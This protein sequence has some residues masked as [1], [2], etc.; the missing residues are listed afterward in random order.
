M[1][2]C[3]VALILLAGTVFASAQTAEQLRA[4]LDSNQD[5]ALRSAAKQ[6]RLPEFY[7]GMVEASENKLDPARRDL[8]RTIRSAPHSKDALDAREALANMALRNGL[9]REALDQIEAAHVEKPGSADVN[10]ML[11]LFRALADS[12][13][14]KVVSRRD[15]RVNCSDGLSL[16]INGKQVSYGFDTGANLSLMGEADAKLLGLDVRHLD[17]KLS[18]SSGTPV[19]GFSLAVA[20]DVVLGGLHLQ[21]VPFFVLND[22]G[23]PFN[24]IPVGG[25][26]LI[27]LPVLI[28]MEAVRWDPA[29]GE[30]QFGTGVRVKGPPTEN[31]LFHGLTPIVQVSVNGKP[32]IFSLDTGAV[33]TDLNEGFAKALPDLVKAGQK[34]TRA[35]TGLGGSNNYDSVLLGPVVFRVGGL[36]VTLKSPHVFPAHSLGK[37]DGNM[38]NDILKQARAI[39]LD[40]RVME[41]QLE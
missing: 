26:G 4:M 39:T 1:K 3:G 14:M 31:L 29:A 40:F 22:T 33:D 20:K 15:S 9:F 11:P 13:N 37:F 32:L 5:F 10:N 12:P 17:T 18:E 16:T 2:A 28:A 24:K 30:C 36:D 35:I 21:N 25:R 38:G 19:S 27:G 23:E 34:E 7:R 41:M 6:H 8:R